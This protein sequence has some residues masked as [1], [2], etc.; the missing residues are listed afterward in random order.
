MLS[1][2]KPAVQNA[3][4]K[5]C[6]P[7]LRSGYSIDL[8]PLEAQAY[9]PADVDE[10]RM[11]Q[12][13]QPA[14]DDQEAR[15]QP[16]PA[17]QPAAPSRGMFASCKPRTVGDHEEIVEAG[18]PPAADERQFADVVPP[19]AQAKK[20]M[21]SSCMQVANVATSCSLDVRREA[22]EKFDGDI[23]YDNGDAK[24]AYVQMSDEE[25][26][27]T[28]G[29]AARY[30][31][32]VAGLHKTV[33][34]LWQIVG[35]LVL[36]VSSL[37]GALAWME[38]KTLSE[39]EKAQAREVA[40][41]GS[42]PIVAL[43]FTWFHIWLAIQMMFRPLKFVGLWEAGEGVGIGWQGLVPRKAEKMARMSYVCARPYLDGPG[44]WLA[45]VD[46]RK[47]VGQFRP[48]LAEIIKQTLAGVGAKHLPS[49]EK[50]LP[51]AAR[52]RL[53]NNAVDKIQETSPMLWKQFS[54]L[55]VDPRI[56]VDNDG[57]I[58]KVFT[59]NKALLNKFFLS[60]G[61][62]EF[63]FI[64]HCGAAMGFLCGVVQLIAFNNLEGTARAVFLPVTGFFL[65]I[66]SNWLAILMVFK[67][68]F[69]IPVRIGSWHIYNIQGLFLKRQPEVA[70]LYSKLLC[71]HF[72]SFNK[73]VDYLQTQPEL[74]AK[75]K[76]AYVEHN[77]RVLRE[78]LGLAGS[79]APFALGKAQYEALEED[80]KLALVHKLYEAKH[81]QKLA[82]TY[83]GKVSNIE[84]N[85]CRAL[86][87][88]PPDK[89]EGLLHPVFQEDEWILILLGG[90]LGAIVGLLQIF[91]LS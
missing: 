77:T 30:V 84:R 15:R 14:A 85:N 82:G 32:E 19:S 25:E 8:E 3:A 81:I 40:L 67:P 20:G 86:Q 2:C 58:V 64:E 17:Q 13:G 59:E 11:R 41:L 57:M 68:V 69:P 27:D 89:F 47:L 7:Q 66:V 71:E 44:D 24:C 48:Q 38:Y 88:M 1:R 43:L 37:A 35:V 91:S 76:D 23:T 80:L 42:I 56:G 51:A 54:K 21:L 31:A 22:S 73:V 6:R 55:L 4:G 12:Q 90:I 45:R 18:R 49:L 63:R 61:E 16:A 83:I 26:E 52:E 75:L 78:T 5:L 70:V 29:A 60:L 65:G 9:L 62:N 39:A 72:L 87:S 33:K 53:A 28:D 10:P 79:L 46:A 34:G 74:W 36:L 50:S